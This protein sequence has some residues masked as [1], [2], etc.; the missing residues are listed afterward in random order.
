MKLFD[1]EIKLIKN[2]NGELVWNVSQDLDECS[3]FLPNIVCIP[4]TFFQIIFD[5]Q[6]LIKAHKK[7]GS[8]T[9]TFYVDLSGKESGKY[10]I[11]KINP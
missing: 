11:S 10:L 9:N 8:L 4:S 7:E 1:S 3:L 2:Q 6:P 5:M